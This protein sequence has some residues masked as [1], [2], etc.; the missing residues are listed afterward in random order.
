MKKIDF[1]DIRLVK[2]MKRQEVNILING[3]LELHDDIFL[4]G[5][6]EHLWKCKCEELFPKKWSNIKP[7]PT[8]HMCDN[9]KKK[10]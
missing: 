4:G 6:H 10:Y 1:K 8:N 3:W 9:C 2:G 7:N 5:K